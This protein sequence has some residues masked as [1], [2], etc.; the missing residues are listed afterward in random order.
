MLLYAVV[1]GLVCL[2]VIPFCICWYNEKKERIK[3]Q[4]LMCNP[5]LTHYFNG[6]DRKCQCGVLDF[7]G[8]LL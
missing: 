8:I 1:I 6:A 7:R 4:D 3:K 5:P 2:Y